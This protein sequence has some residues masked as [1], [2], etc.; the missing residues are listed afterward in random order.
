[1]LARRS[2]TPAPAAVSSSRGRICRKLRERCSWFTWRPSI[3]WMSCTTASAASGAV[4][5]TKPKPRGRPVWRSRIT[6]CEQGQRSWAW[7]GPCCWREHEAQVE[8]PASRPACSAQRSPPPQWIHICQSGRAAF[9]HDKETGC[10]VLNRKGRG[11]APR[12]VG[13]RRLRRRRQSAVGGRCLLHAAAALPRNEPPERCAGTPCI[14]RATV[15]APGQLGGWRNQCC[16]PSV[17]SQLRPPKNSLLE[18]LQVEETSGGSLRGQ[19]AMSRSLN[20]AGR[21]PT[22]LTASSGGGDPSMAS[23]RF[24]VPVTTSLPY[25]CRCCDWPAWRA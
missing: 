11:R 15:Q 3:T 7:S 10:W 6:T 16:V 12:G 25:S 13:L 2:H 1:M 8:R 17:V 18:G 20:S 4:K 19:L 14:R 5:V 21:G 22:H 24:E 23:I 9:L